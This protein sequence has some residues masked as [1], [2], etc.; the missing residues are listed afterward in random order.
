MSEDE[1]WCQV[2]LAALP[3]LLTT[4]SFLRVNDKKALRTV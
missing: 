1:F 4:D 2:Y 3:P